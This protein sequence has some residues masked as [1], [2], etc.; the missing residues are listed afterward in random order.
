MPLSSKFHD[1]R[2]ELT[3]AVEQQAAMGE[4]LSSIATSPADAAPVFETIM[5]NAVRLC[6]SPL[7]AIYAFDG[8]LVHLAGTYNWP[9][10]WIRHA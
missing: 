7:A 10:E 2:H 4:I 6:G 1:M 3:A 8:E 9:P 5:K